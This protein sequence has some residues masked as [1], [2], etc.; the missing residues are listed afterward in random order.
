M[1]FL[2]VLWERSAEVWLG[3][4]FLPYSVFQDFRWFWNKPLNKLALATKHVACFLVVF[5]DRCGFGREKVRAGSGQD[6]LNSYECGAGLK[7][8]WVGRE[9]ARYQLGTLGGAK[10]FPRESQIFW[11][12]SN[13][14]E[15]C[16]THFSRGANN[17]LGLP[18]VTGLGGSRQKIST[19]AGQKLLIQSSRKFAWKPLH[20]S[21]VLIRWESSCILP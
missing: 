12:R 4:T 15:L 18:L 14:F 10:S 9:Q 17:F 20:I 11:T 19:R 2:I 8:A 3:F 6:F 1:F 7:F 13:V 5:R 21:I 16:P